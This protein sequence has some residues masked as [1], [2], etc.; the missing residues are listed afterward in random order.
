[1][2]GSNLLEVVVD[3]ELGSDGEDGHGQEPFRGLLFG[4]DGDVLNGQ[5]DLLAVV[6]IG[7]M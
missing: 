4:A 6:G 5:E 3:L 7:T 2:P 1:M